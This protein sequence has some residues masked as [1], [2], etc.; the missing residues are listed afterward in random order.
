MGDVQV[1]II[2][3]KSNIPLDLKAVHQGRV[4]AGMGMLISEMSE[5]VIE[6]KLVLS[7]FRRD[8]GML[9]NA[10]AVIDTSLQL[11][12]D[13]KDS[14]NRNSR[15]I[16][17]IVA[18]SAEV[19]RQISQIITENKD[20]L[21]KGFDAVTE[22]TEELKLTLTEFRKTSESIRGLSNKVSSEGS[23]I[24]RL[25]SEEDLYDN[26]QQSI[27]RLDSL[28]QDIEENPKK[29]FKFSVF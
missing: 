22:I 17:N 13:L 21:N 28:L 24:N 18:K 1:E 11:V 8:D 23:A 3:G 9:N 5:V 15:S 12:S 10:R 25:I 2:P 19:S 6:L 14:F 27:S 7:E 4:K 26:L 29:Y 16:D 20:D